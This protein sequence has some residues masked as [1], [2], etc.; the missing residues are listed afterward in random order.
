MGEGLYPN[1]YQLLFPTENP[2]ADTQDDQIRDRV[3][4]STF[5]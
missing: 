5:L 1:P 2:L 4:R 3:S